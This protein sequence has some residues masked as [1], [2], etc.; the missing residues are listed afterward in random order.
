MDREVV[1]RNIALLGGLLLL[2]NVF[3]FNRD[4]KFEFISN[5]I[6]FGA[7]PLTVVLAS[8][9]FKKNI[10]LIGIVLYFISYSSNITYHLFEVSYDNV[11][12]QQERA[13]R[14][15]GAIGLGLVVLAGTDSLNKMGDNWLTKTIKK[16]ELTVLVI[17]SLTFLSAT[18]LFLASD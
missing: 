3:Y 1:Y 12:V 2:A 6:E 15:I 13:L 7:V 17:A 14:I 11:I 10:V 18:G 4:P 5:I 9:M 8:F 16:P